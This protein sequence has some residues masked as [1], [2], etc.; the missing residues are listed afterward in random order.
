[1]RENPHR[2]QRSV[3]PLHVIGWHCC[4][5]HARSARHAPGRDAEF[6]NFISQS[7][8]KRLAAELLQ[9]VRRSRVAYKRIA[10]AARQ[11]GN[12]PEALAGYQSHLARQP[13]DAEAYNDLGIVYCHL[14]RFDDASAAYSAAI[15]LDSSLLSAH[16]NLGHMA[17]QEKR[18][19]REA[20]SHYQRVLQIDSRH[21]DAI[22]QICI[23]YYEAGELAASL[24]TLSSA[25]RDCNDPVALEFLLFMM[26]A[27]PGHDAE[28]HFQLHMR[29]SALHALAAKRPKAARK[30]AR[31]RHGGKIRV[32]YVSADFREHAVARFLLPVMERHNRDRFEVFCY[33]NQVETDSLTRQIRATEI[34]WREVLKLDDVAFCNLVQ[35]DGIDI[36]VD[37]SGHTRGNRLGTFEMEPAPIQLA[38]LGYLNTTG[39]KSMQFRI[40]DSDLDPVGIADRLHTERLI[41]LDPGSW[42]YRAPN[43]EVDIGVGPCEVQG[44][45][46][47]ASINHIAK[48]NE[49]LFDCWAALLRQL[50]GSRLKLFGI[51]DQVAAD[52]IVRSFAGMGVTNDRL[53]L[54]PRLSR[55]E[56][57]SELRTSDI[58]LDS[59]PYTGGATTC[60]TLWM[61]VPVVALAGDF[62]FSRSSAAMLTQAG[63]AEFVAASCDKYREIAMELANGGRLPH[64]RR[65]MRDR[66]KGSVL[67]DERG[68]VSRLESAYQSLASQEPSQ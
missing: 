68:F 32:G 51:P 46:T 37:L 15:S 61:G 36:L 28:M 22:H 55:S 7:M 16:L 29:W 23:A 33:A 6:S 30:T 13:D 66:L 59:F 2:I 3:L 56:F 1:M 62:G 40:T 20:I 14:G 17:L 67:M 27:S 39:M 44:H 31:G 26:N 5:Q 24:D 52:R 64:W 19:Y 65:T 21:A 49:K 45:I 47:F 60:E 54:L 63:L 48:L 35:Q 43:E 41:R 50:P 11:N 58:A 10:D 42:A 25:V 18:N 57:C 9:R 53:T 12:W 38:W 4:R 8:L 34:A